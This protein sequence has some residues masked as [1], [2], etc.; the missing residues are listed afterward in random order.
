M[1]IP[2]YVT[3]EE[4]IIKMIDA[5][6]IDLNKVKETAKSLEERLE[7]LESKT[8]TYDSRNR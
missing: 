3:S 6:Y 5:L 1:K 4:T 7:R 8:F 2:V